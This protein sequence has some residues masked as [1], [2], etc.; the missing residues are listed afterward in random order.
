VRGAR[1]GPQRRDR[2]V[3]SKEIGMNIEI[4]P[5]DISPGTRVIL[6]AER[7]S[8]GHTCRYI[9]KVGD[10]EPVVTDQP[11]YAWTASE[12]GSYRVSVQAELHPQQQEN[13]PHGVSSWQGETS[14]DVS[15][16]RLDL[17]ELKKNIDGKA[18]DLTDAV[19]SIANALTSG[20]PHKVALQQTAFIDAN[21]RELAAFFA[22]IR[23]RTAAIA[24]PHYKEFIDRL[25]C[26][27]SKYDQAG[28]TASA[29]N[30]GIPSIG[31]RR[32]ELQ[33]RPTIYGVDAYNLLKTAT[34]AF[35]VF[36]AGFAV[37]AAR[38]DQDGIAGDESK[39]LGEDVLF[40]Q[41]TERLHQYLNCT[42]TPYLRNI[43]SALVGTE[44]P[45]QKLPYCDGVLRNRFTCPSLLELIWSYWHEEGGLVQTLNAI[46]LRFQ[47][48]RRGG[49][50]DPLAHLEIDPLRPLNNL[51][52]GYVQDE[53]HRLTLPRRAYE[54]DHHYGLTIE[55]KAV[56]N[57]RGADS[58]S[59]FLE[60]FHNLLYRTS[61]F[62]PEDADQTVVADAFPMLNALREVHLLLAEGAHNQFGD[63]PWT[64]RG[65][66]L[67]QQ[68]LLARPE[69]REFLRGR[70][71]VP[72]AESWMGQVDTMKRLQGWSE[73]NITN[74]YELGTFGEQLLLSIRCHNWNSI[75]EQ[76]EAKLW[77]RYWKPEI[78][79]YI[80]SY[81]AVTGVDLT[82]EPVDATLPSV[83]LRTRLAEEQRRRAGRA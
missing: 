15:P 39:R 20:T 54:Y 65:E 18:D 16:A 46:A 55:G 64:A 74:F 67:I 26:P 72:Y 1:V 44:N 80:H 40:D 62:Y 14:V 69:M 13:A 31:Q 23:N 4:S 24:F 81:R 76:N 34:E 6:R 66:M 43:V 12:P 83:H 27:D 78:Q 33:A 42:S 82:S 57:I 37:T 8:A 28:R 58:R 41:I 35:L 59:K 68:W 29:A 71:M 63:L 7:P 79:R 3:I 25:L 70:A 19:R 36:E 22:S 47:N 53:T 38:A 75:N 9:W 5:T 60:A 73:V 48:R 21:L 61:Q 32:D 50:R 11:E 17:R 77:A 51:L 52:W 56:P 2:L 30:Y 45:Q 49:E 10:A